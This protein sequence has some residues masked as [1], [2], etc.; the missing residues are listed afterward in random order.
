MKKTEVII[1]GLYSVK[2]SGQVVPVRIIAESPHGGWVGKNEVT[3][4]EVRIRT[5]ARL[6]TNINRL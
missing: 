3:G 1:G 5:A 4:K 6:R 2:V